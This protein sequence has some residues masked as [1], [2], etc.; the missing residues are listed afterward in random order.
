VTDRPDQQLIDVRSHALALAVAATAP[1]DGLLLQLRVVD[2]AD[3]LEAWILRAPERTEVFT[4]IRADL[5]AELDGRRQ[6]GGT[7]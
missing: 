1:L 4:E 7:T 5:E 2:F 3:Y 6:P